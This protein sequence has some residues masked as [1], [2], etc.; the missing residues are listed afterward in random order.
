MK[1]VSAMTDMVTVANGW[2]GLNV[3]TECQVPGL[4]ALT[5]DDGIGY[6]IHSKYFLHELFWI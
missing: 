2:H 1:H 3:V 6:I 4:V 5:Y